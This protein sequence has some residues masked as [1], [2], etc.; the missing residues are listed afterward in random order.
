MF[1][2]SLRRARLGYASRS[3]E[4]I[5][6]LRCDQRGVAAIEFALFASAISIGMLNVVDVAI[7]AYQK[8]EVDNATEMAAQAAWK[9]CNTSSLLPATLNCSGLNAA[10]T[11]AVQSTSLGTRVT[12]QSGSP[13]EGYYCVNSSSALV[14]V[15]SVS[16]KPANCSSVGMAGL[17][18]AD[19][20]QVST[21]FTYSP[22]FRGITVGGALPTSI[23][24][25]ALMRMG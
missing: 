12:L 1:R 4:K 10:V 21:T 13:A 15:S 20:I 8:M 11:A 18:P 19:Y 24:S 23:T 14:Y 5:K 17:Q 16:S 7:F 6:S 25:T 9:T 2:L 22:I 3:G